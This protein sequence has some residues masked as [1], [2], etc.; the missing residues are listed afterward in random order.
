MSFLAIQ[1]GGISRGV[2]LVMAASLW[3]LSGQHEERTAKWDERKETAFKRHDGVVMSVAFSPDGK[4]VA[5]ASY[6]EVKLWDVATGKETLKFKP[7]RKMVFTS[8]AISPDGRT[9]AGGQCRIKERKESRKG[10]VIL[11]AFIYHGEVLIWDLQTGQLKA[12][13]NDDNN[14]VWTLAFSPNGDWLAAGSGPNLQKDGERKDSAIGEVILW[15]TRTW[16]LIRKLKGNAAPVR[17]L[18]FSPDNR[19]IIGA[20][21]V[22]EGWG[23]GS[24]EGKEEFEL[25]LW[26]V[27]SGELKHAFPGHLQ[28]VTGLAFSPDGRW[29][30]SAGRDRALKIW[31]IQTYQLKR[32]AS[33]HKLSLEEI[34]T[35]QDAAGGKGAKQA[36]LARSWLNAILFSNDGKEVIGGAGNGT[37]RFYD[38]GS[39]EIS[40]VTNPRDWPIAPRVFSVEPIEPGGRW[41]TITRWPAYYGL[42]NSMALAP[43]GKTLAMGNADGKIRLMILE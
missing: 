10:D 3:V 35:I 40:R 33:D 9:L 13:L 8:V 24:V 22:I 25:L 17:S 11:T 18:A 27:E 20:G 34:Q 2:L 37:I 41:R 6:D 42:L 29:L 36:I 32:S 5:S 1:F 28:S 15:D 21:G 31:D 4:R 39:L 7:S 19:M 30:A 16:K 26:D 14:S 12:T 38:S 23:E 43:D